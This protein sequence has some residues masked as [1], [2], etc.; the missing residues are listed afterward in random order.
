MKRSTPQGQKL[1]LIAG[2]EFSVLG[3]FIMALLALIALFSLVSLGLFLA[4]PD[5]MRASTLA[6]KTLLLILVLMNIALST[7]LLTDFFNKAGR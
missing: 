5:L 2:R 6:D 1:V 4:R 7:F 3:V